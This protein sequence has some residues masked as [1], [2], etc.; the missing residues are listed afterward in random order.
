M[1][2]SANKETSYNFG[3]EFTTAPKVGKR[4]RS[5]RLSARFYHSDCS[6][7]RMI[8][9][10]RAELPSGINGDYVTWTLLGLFITREHGQIPTQAF[11]SVASDYTGVPDGI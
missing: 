1:T 9:S 7:Q 10:K 6:T 3:P 4:F 8:T 5:Y 11:F 2:V